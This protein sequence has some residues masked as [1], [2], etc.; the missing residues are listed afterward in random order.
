MFSIM[1]YLRTRVP[2]VAAFVVVIGGVT[3]PMFWMVYEIENLKRHVVPECRIRLEAD[4]ASNALKQLRSYAEY[5]NAKANYLGYSLE[6]V[7]PISFRDALPASQ[8]NVQLDD[9]IDTAKHQIYGSWQRIGEIGRNLSILKGDIDRCKE[10]ESL[11]DG[12]EPG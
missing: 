11:G 12:W 6:Q 5:V 7:G 8:R 9:A 2:A 1:N 3:G 10:Q 4:I